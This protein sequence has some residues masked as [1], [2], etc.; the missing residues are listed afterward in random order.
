MPR[1]PLLLVSVLLACGDSGSDT[2][3]TSMLTTVSATATNSNTSADDSSS[4]ASEPTTTAPPGDTTADATTDATTT[5]PD[6]TTG[7][8]DVTGTTAPSSTTSS[9]TSSTTDATTTAADESS[10]TTDPAICGDAF[11]GP[12]EACDDGLTL[13]C[14]GTHDGGDGTCVPA[15]ECSPGY[16][17]ADAECVPESMA[18]HVHIMVSNNCDMTVDPEEFSVLPGQKLKIAYHNHSVDY[19]V[20]VWMHYNGGF[21]DLQPGGTWNEQY[22]HCFGPNPSEG[23]ADITTACSEFHLP[24]HCL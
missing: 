11:L 12:G 8:A 22:E 10:S 5:A 3:A 14:V 19:P 13:D 23:Y 2:T 1:L 7:I 9:S 17:L 6:D 18:A 4:S 15:G 21:L 16:I 20:D 24:I